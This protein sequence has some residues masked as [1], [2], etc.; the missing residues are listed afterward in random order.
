MLVIFLTARLPIH[1]PASYLFALALPIAAG[2]RH[3]LRLIRDWLDCL[4]PRRHATVFE[5]VGL[6]VLIFLAGALWLIVLKP[7]VSTD[8]LDTHMAVAANMAMH[9]AFTVDFR[10]FVWALMPLGADWCYSV[11]W[12]LGGEYASRLLNFALLLSTLMLLFRAARRFV[13]VGLATFLTAL[14]L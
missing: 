2:Y 14:F 3:S 1:Y 9:H 11:V 12:M 8:G 10:E 7:E 13:P 4:R 6:A 5:H